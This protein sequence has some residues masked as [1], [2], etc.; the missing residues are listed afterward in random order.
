MVSRLFSI[1]IWNDEY[2]V[3][4]ANHSQKFD[5]IVIH[6]MIRL[7]SLPYA[8]PI[9]YGSDSRMETRNRKNLFKE[10]SLIIRIADEINSGSLA[11]FQ[12]GKLA[13]F[14][15]PMY[16]GYTSAVIADIFISQG[17]KRFMS[18]PQYR[19]IIEMF[20]LWQRFQK[21]DNIAHKIGKPGFPIVQRKPKRWIYI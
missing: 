18:Y 5:F 6:E 14:N 2:F 15:D 1:G 4:T 10:Q 9:F 7:N 17:G 16:I 8:K 20:R 19:D 21:L 13:T 12:I 11:L 3:V